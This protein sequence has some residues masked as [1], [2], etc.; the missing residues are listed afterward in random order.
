MKNIVYF[1]LLLSIT[2]FSQTNKVNI[3]NFNDLID[4]GNF[5]YNKKLYSEAN[6]IYKYAKTFAIDMHLG[7]KK[8]DEAEKKRVESQ[9]KIDEPK[10]KP[11]LERKKPI[12]TT[13]VIKPIPIKNLSSSKKYSNLLEEAKIVYNDYAQELIEKNKFDE[14]KELY[15]K[16]L[17]YDPNN[18]VT[19][20]NL[21]SL[22][23]T[24]DQLKQKQTKLDQKKIEQ[25]Q[26]EELYEKVNDISQLLTY[27]NFSL[28]NKEE[29]TSK[30]IAQKILKIEDSPKMRDSISS[31]Y[32]N[33][34]GNSHF[35]EFFLSNTAKIKE[36]RDFYL[37]EK[38]VSKTN[39][40]KSF[41]YYS[42]LVEL[43]LEYLKTNPEN[44]LVI[45]FQTSQHYN[46]KGWYSMLCKKFDNLLDYFNASLK[47]RSANIVAEGNIPHAY[48]FT[49]QIEKAK[50]LYLSL[51]DQGFEKFSQYKTFKEAFL[52]DFNT[53]R[54]AGIKNNDMDKIQKLLE[55]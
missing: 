52:A 2:A 46:N 48:L 40:L 39:Y 21:F 37:Y 12:P 43:D 51:K 7:Q 14:A 8:I 19:T 33:I 50:E 6:K 36:Y 9:N 34:T 31:S 22:N 29:E 10:N 1:I 5:N 27:L 3:K 54:E 32:F 44:L 17:K 35:K 23:S 26:F 16:I 42:N 30:T 25:K 18:A 45:Q 28:E 47:Y 38:I 20:L 15:E 24:L 41:E 4:E 55:Q 11:E 13:Q 53:F 49:N